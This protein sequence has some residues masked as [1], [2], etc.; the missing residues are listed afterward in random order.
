[1]GLYN[2]SFYTNLNHYQKLVERHNINSG[3]FKRTI[4]MDLIL[5]DE[6]Y[7]YLYRLDPSKYFNGYKLI[8]SDIVLHIVVKDKI[9]YVRYSNAAARKIQK[10]VEILTL[11]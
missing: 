9:L 2:Y 1:M 6:K 3:C 4:K 8:C 5:V 7:Y 10:K 11:I